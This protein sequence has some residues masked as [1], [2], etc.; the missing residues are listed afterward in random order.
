MAIANASS[1][2]AKVRPVKED[3]E[4]AQPSA[5]A[6]EWLSRRPPQ[7]AARLGEAKLPLGWQI[8]SKHSVAGIGR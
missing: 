1:E 8:S 2:P 6:H 7:G 5:H 4:R 3:L